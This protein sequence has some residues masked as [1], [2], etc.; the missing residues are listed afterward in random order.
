MN[1]KPV[2]FVGDVDIH[3]LENYQG[4]MEQVKPIVEKYVGE[5]L[6]RVGSM[7][8]FETASIVQ[9][10]HRNVA[11]FIIFFF[12]IIVTTVYKNNNLIYLRKITFIL[13]IFLLLQIFLGI[14]TILSGAQMFYASM[15]QIG[16]ILLISTSLILL[17]KNSKIN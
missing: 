9:F 4:Y 15:H 5:Y 14:V 17:F 8:A 7:E 13:F 6:T 1:K 3:N 2:Y 10:I 12:L 16:S 11:Y